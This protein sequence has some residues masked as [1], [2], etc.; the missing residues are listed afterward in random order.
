MLRLCAVVR[1]PFFFSGMIFE[2][3]LLLDEVGIIGVQVNK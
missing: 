1:F 3:E 2:M